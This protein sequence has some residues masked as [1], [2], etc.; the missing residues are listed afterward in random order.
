MKQQRTS[1]SGIVLL[2]RLC[3]VPFDC[4]ASHTPTRGLCEM[5]TPPAP[6]S[7]VPHRTGPGLGCRDFS[8]LSSLEAL[9]F[10]R[11]SG[12]ARAPQ[13]AGFTGAGATITDA[14]T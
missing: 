13:H 11:G 2:P 1:I 5:R 8:R 7:P 3:A 9:G 12:R 4:T 10:G 14:A 6:N